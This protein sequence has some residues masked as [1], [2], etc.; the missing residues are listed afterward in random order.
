MYNTYDTTNGLQPNIGGPSSQ[1]NMN[2]PMSLIH[3]FSVDEFPV[4]DY[5]QRALLEYQAEYGV[6]FTLLH[7]WAEL[8]DG[9]KKEEVKLPDFEAKRQEKNK[10]YKSLWSSSFNTTHST[11]VSFTLK[12]EARDDEEDEVHEVQRLMVRGWRHQHRQHL[13]KVNDSHYNM[14]LI[15]YIEGHSLPFGHPEFALIIGLR[16]GTVSF[17]L[18]TFGELKFHNKVFPHKLGSILTNLD[19][20][21]VIEDK[22]TYGKLCDEDSI[23]WNAFPW[24]EH[25]WT[26]L[27]DEIKNVIEKNSN[28][29]YFGLKKDRNYVPT[30]TLAGFVFA[31]QVLARERNDEVERL[32]FNEDFSCMSRD[33]FDSLNILFHDLINPRD[34]NEDID[35]GSLSVSFHEAMIIP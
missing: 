1:P 32:Q 19:V 4:K 22:E 17:G 21:G 34:L 10:L 2:P 7:V 18:Y 13:H 11:E 33:F 24:G 27:Y 5:T 14:P 23:P 8:K 25:V 15:Y 31:F 3:Q 26:H 28:E 20:I 30:Y 16:F 12:M 9:S 29:H 6:P 35:N